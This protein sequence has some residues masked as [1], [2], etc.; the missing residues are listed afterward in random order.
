MKHNEKPCSKCEFIETL[1]KGM[2]QS[3][4][5]KSRS[6]KKIKIKK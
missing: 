2:C 3:C 5:R 6:I 4:Y 1:V